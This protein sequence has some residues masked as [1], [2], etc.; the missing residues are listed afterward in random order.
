[1]EL[2]IHPLYNQKSHI[3]VH[4]NTAKSLNLQYIKDSIIRFG[5]SSTEVNVVID[6]S[7]KENEIHLSEAIIKKL[8]IPT[9]CPYNVI[10]KNNAIVIGPFIGIIIGN[11][12]SALSRRMKQLNSYVKYYS[13]IKGVVFGFT[14]DCVNK[15]DM[16]IEGV[17]FNPQYQVW[18]IVTLPFP[19]SLM[20][21]G[22]VNQKWREYFYSLY[23]EKFFNYKHIDKWLMYQKLRQFPELNIHLPVTEL[24]IGKTSILNFLNKHPNIYV[25]PIRGNRG[26][27]IFNIVKRENIYKVFTRKDQQNIE[28]EFNKETFLDFINENLESNQ[29]IMQKTLDLIIDNR[30]IDFRIGLDRNQEGNWN[31]IMYVTR[32]SG[33]QSIVSNVASSGG[34]VLYPEDALQK[35]YQFNKSDALKMKEKLLDIAFTIAEKLD[36]SGLKLGKIAL[37]LALDSEGNIYLIEVNN[38][39]PNDNILAG[40]GDTDTFYRIRHMNIR[41]AKG[42]SGFKSEENPSLI[43]DKEVQSN[44]SN[45]IR[46]II[47]IAIPKELYGAF[48]QEFKTKCNELSIVGFMDLNHKRRSKIEVE[49]SIKNLEKLLLYVSNRYK[50]KDLLMKI[51][52]VVALCN[53]YSFRFIRSQQSNNRTK[54]LSISNDQ[55]L[56]YEN[57]LKSLKRENERL[58]RQNTYMRRSKSWKFTSPFR[59]ALRFF[60]SF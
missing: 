21:R 8:K 27:G 11:K 18:E 22:L 4:E 50:D 3:L 51:D 24:Y 41:Y 23:G 16:V 57:Q 32:I 29:F 6:N 30:T 36:E 7:V 34:F 33:N 54:S 37:D 40:L 39:V 5:Y 46:Y 26:L 13:K 10:V 56:R 44:M 60:K 38:K 52:K 1:M 25:K 20:R 9:F 49:G 15:E 47:T 55:I 14:L 45:K 59:Y 28:M 58:K 2:T 19:A 42:L 12:R 53:E 31:N 35:F 17:V 43:F 48:K